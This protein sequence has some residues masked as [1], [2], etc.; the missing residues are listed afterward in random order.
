[1]GD[2]NFLSAYKL[3]NSQLVLNNQKLKEEMKDKIEMINQLN[4]QLFKYREENKTLRDMVN[5]MKFG[6][7][8]TNTM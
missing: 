2:S 7:V 1:M 6:L 3:I 4:E 5:A 8:F